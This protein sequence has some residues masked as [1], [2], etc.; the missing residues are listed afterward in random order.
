MNTELMM[1][2][3]SS[4]ISHFQNALAKLDELGDAVPTHVTAAKQLLGSAI[5]SAQ[6]AKTAKESGEECT[7]HIKAALEIGEAVSALLEMPYDE[8]VTR[9]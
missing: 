4:A 2:Q 7:T 6:M 5:R 1:E 3:I 9:P 8:Q